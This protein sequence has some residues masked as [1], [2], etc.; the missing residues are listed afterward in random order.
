MTPAVP[1]RRRATAL[2][3]LLALSLLS[4][5]REVTGPDGRRLA[6]LAFAPEFSGPVA[7]VEG[8]GDVEPFEKVR[9]VLRRSDGSILRDTTVNFPSTAT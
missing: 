5:G 8:A 3:A 7:V 6:L 2:A 1:T 4:C 9:V